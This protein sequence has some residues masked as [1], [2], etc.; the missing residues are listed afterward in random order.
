[1][2]AWLHVAQGWQHGG[3]S[4]RWGGGGVEWRGG[5]VVVVQRPSCSFTAKAIKRHMR[6]RLSMPPMSQCWIPEEEQCSHCELSPALTL[7][8]T[9]GVVVPENASYN[10]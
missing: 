10:L 4:M 5:G 1:M 2:S 9:M 7:T 6:C 3:A 8:R